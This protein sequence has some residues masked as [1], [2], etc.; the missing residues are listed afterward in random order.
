MG[1]FFFVESVEGYR[2]FF[3]FVDDCTRVTWVYMLK[4]KS[5]VSSVFPTFLKLASTKY[6]ATIKAIRSD[7]APKLAFTDLI[8]EHGMIHY[9]SCAYTP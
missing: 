5:K 6:Q 2:Y 1:P 3:I 9:F 7:N 8:K 4:N